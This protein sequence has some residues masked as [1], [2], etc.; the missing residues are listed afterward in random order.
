LRGED[1]AVVAAAADERRRVAT[2]LLIPR[3]DRNVAGGPAW[4][5]QV[6]AM[7]GS[8]AKTLAHLRSTAMLD[9]TPPVAH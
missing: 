6:R 8:P 9:M 1:P 5:D 2:Q 4:L 3:T 7:A